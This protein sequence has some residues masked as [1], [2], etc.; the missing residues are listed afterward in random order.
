MSKSSFNRISRRVPFFN[1]YSQEDCREIIEELIEEGYKL[2]NVT[3]EFFVK[4]QL[5]ENALKS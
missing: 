2:K 4:L 1:L 3:E 5:N